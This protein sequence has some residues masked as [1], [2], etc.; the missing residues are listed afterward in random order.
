MNEAHSGYKRNIRTRKTGIDIL[1][2]AHK[3]GV[4][5]LAMEALYS[6]YVEE[7]NHLRDVS[8]LS[9]KAYLAQ[10]EMSD[11]VQRALD[12]GWT[13]VRYEADFSNST[14][15]GTTPEGI[16]WREE[17]Q[18]INLKKALDDLPEYTKLL[19]WCGNF[20]HRLI[21]RDDWL[22]MGYQFKQLSG[23]A[24]FVI[25]QHRTIEF[26]N[27]GENKLKEVRAIVNEFAP[28]LTTFGGTAGFLREESYQHEDLS[29]SAYIYSLNN[30][31][32]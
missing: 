2:T 32:E 4:R 7:A 30:A 28:V 26:P 10:P 9:P 23:I 20:H 11:L 1:E 31:M 18:A 27:A 6:P 21:P 16:N 29:A 14:L 3:A 15:D 22:P 12:L 17:Q 19:V 24:P 13:L 5:H 8:T 25:H